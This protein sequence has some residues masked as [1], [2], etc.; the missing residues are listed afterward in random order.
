MVGQNRYSGV[1]GEKLIGD[2]N[3]HYAFISQRRYAGKP[4]KGLAPGATVT[5]Q[6]LEDMAPFFDEK[7]GQ[8]VDNRMEQLTV[9]IVGVDFPLPFKKGDEVSVD[10]FLSEHS[11]FIDYSFIL[12]FSG[13]RPYKPQTATTGGSKNDVTTGTK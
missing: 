8:M 7:S 3:N 10:G 2:H 13:I 11:Y 12:R 9:T 1:L 5:L 4:E 6:I